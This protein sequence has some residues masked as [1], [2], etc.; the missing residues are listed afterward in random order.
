[1]VLEAL[2]KGDFRDIKN[3]NLLLSFGAL[4]VIQVLREMGGISGVK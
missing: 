2:I 4:E 1:M 3:C